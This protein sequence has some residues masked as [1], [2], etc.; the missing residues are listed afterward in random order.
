[1]NRK[2][3]LE[4][5]H[6]LIEKM[7]N[8][9]NSIDSEQRAMSSTEEDY[10]YSLEN[11]VVEINQILANEEKQENIGGINMEKREFAQALLKNELRA[12]ST[13]HS[14]AIPTNISNEIIKKLYEVSN[15]VADAQYV[16]ANGDLEF[17]VEKKM[18]LLKF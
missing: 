16:Q 12:D 11:E 15:V 9:I 10:Y 5:K 4:K 2:Q 14:N 17:L 8:I 18:V 7:E 6:E 13:T 3:L 1:M